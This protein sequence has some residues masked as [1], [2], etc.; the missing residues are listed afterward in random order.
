ML[1]AYKWKITGVSPLLLNNPEGTMK[2]A[3]GGVAPKKKDY[4]DKEEADMRVYRDDAGDY[5]IPTHW[6][7]AAILLAAKGRK[8][9]KLGARTVFGGT[10]YPTAMMAKL[11]DGNGS[12]IKKHSH[13]KAPVKIGTARVIRCWPMFDPWGCTLEMEIDEDFI[14]VSEVSTI[15]DVAGRIQGVGDWR[16]DTS[17]GK[18]GGPFGRFKAELVK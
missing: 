13:K 6:F 14:N 12:K 7:R 11:T 10:V 4:D 3:T 5:V 15:L 17:G 16:P 18:K 2:P 9:G 8:I 1:K